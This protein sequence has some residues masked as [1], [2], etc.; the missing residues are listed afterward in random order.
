MLPNVPSRHLDSEHLHTPPFVL[1]SNY[2]IEFDIFLFSYIFVYFLWMSNSIV[3][4]FLK[5][6]TVITLHF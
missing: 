4:T 6:F 2:Y 1:R 5:C 3:F